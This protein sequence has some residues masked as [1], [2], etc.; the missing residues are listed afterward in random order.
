LNAVGDG[1]IADVF[2]EVEKVGILV[3]KEDMR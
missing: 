2:E 1:W 3:N